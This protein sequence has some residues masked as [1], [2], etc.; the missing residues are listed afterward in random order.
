[1]SNNNA[2]VIMVSMSYSFSWTWFFI[3]LAIQVLGVLFVRYYK[4]V[5]DNMGR[6][7]ASY[8]RYKLYAVITCAAGI[9]IMFNF[10]SLIIN[11]IG[12]LIFGGGL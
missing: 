10:H 11:W 3:G 7:V 6:G 9:I 2:R 1:M 12:H 4:Q 5:A 8:D